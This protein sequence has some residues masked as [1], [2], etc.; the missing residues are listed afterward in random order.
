[1]AGFGG[2]DAYAALRLRAAQSVGVAG[3]ATVIYSEM[4]VLPA[5]RP[6]NRYRQ[7]KTHTLNDRSGNARKTATTR[8]TDFSRMGIIAD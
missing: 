6:R 7:H 1:L 5:R 4:I 8:L 3:I 2:I